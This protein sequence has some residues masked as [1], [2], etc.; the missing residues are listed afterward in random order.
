MK[1]I[2]I[3]NDVR[4]N[5]TISRSGLPE[6]FSDASVLVQ[7]LDARD[8]AVPIQSSIAG[9]II[10]VLYQG[11]DQ[12]T[13]GRYKLVLVENKGEAS[14][15]TIDHADAFELVPESRMAAGCSCMDVDL[16]SNIEAG[17]PGTKGEDAKINGHNAVEIVAGENVEIHQEG[18]VLTIGAT[19]GG[20]KPYQSLARR[21]EYLYEITFAQ[22][23]D[24]IPANAA[25]IGGCTSFVRNGRL[26]RNLDWKYDDTPSFIVRTK[27]FDGMAFNSAVNDSS[28]SDTALGQLP[29]MVV[30]GVNR[31]G[32][33]GSVHVLYN[34]FDWHG[35]GNIPLT[36]VMYEILTRV[37][38]MQSIQSELSP[39]IGDIATTPA[40][41]AAEYL[42]QFVITDGVTSYV[43]TPTSDGYELVDI[44][45][46]PKLAN[47]KWVAD[48]EVERDAVNMQLR[49]TGVERWNLIGEDTELSD[50]RFTKC[51]ESAD[52]LSEFVGIDDT[53]KD[54]TDAELTTVYNLAHTAYSTRTR[55][56]QLWQTMHS[57]VYGAN[58][59]E[60]LWC[61][62]KWDKD[63]VAQS[64]GGG[65]QVNSD[66][67]ATSGKAEILN[68][69]FYSKP[70]NKVFEI[71][72]ET[73][74]LMDFNSN[75]YNWRYG[76]H[77]MVLP[78]SL[79]TDVTVTIDGHT[80]NTQLHSG[81]ISD[82]WMMPLIGNLE[83]A[84]AMLCFFL[85][86]SY[87]SDIPFT[88]DIFDIKALLE[89]G[90]PLF[91]GNF[92]PDGGVPFIVVNTNVINVDSESSITID[93]NGHTQT[94]GIGQ[95]I[96]G[97]DF[98]GLAFCILDSLILYP[99]IPACDV[100]LDGEVNHL[101]CMPSDLNGVFV[102][103][104]PVLTTP[105]YINELGGS[106][107]LPLFIVQGICLLIADRNPT[108]V[109]SV[110]VYSGDVRTAYFESVVSF[111]E[112]SDGVFESLILAEAFDKN[113][114]FASGDSLQ[115]YVPEKKL[116][117]RESIGS[118]EAFGYK[119]STAPQN[120]AFESLEFDSP[121]S[122]CSFTD[123]INRNPIAIYEC[124]EKLLPSHSVVH[125]RQ[126]AI[127]DDYAGVVRIEHPGEAVLFGTHFRL[128]DIPIVSYC[129]NFVDVLGTDEDSF[130]G[131]P[132][133]GI[134]FTPVDRDTVIAKRMFGINDECTHMHLG[135]NLM[136][137]TFTTFVDDGR[138]TP[139][140]IKIVSYKT[141]PPNIQYCRDLD[142]Y[143][144]VLGEYVVRNNWVDLKFHKNADNQWESEELAIFS[145]EVSVDGD[146]TIVKGDISFRGENPN[147][148][149]EIVDGE[150]KTTRFV[151][152]GECVVYGS[153]LTLLSADLSVSSVPYAGFE[154]LF[155]DC[156]G[157][158]GAYFDLMC[159]SAD[160]YAFY[161]MFKNSGLE[162]YSGGDFIVW[163]ESEYCGDFAFAEMFEGSNITYLDSAPISCVNSAYRML[164]NCVNLQYFCLNNIPMK[165]SYKEIAAGCSN[166][167]EVYLYEDFINWCDGVGTKDWLK[168][169]PTTG[170]LYCSDRLGTDETIERGADYCPEG[171]TVVNSNNN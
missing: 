60:N 117:W 70:G 74:F 30:D 158:V 144:E 18:N 41:D 23:P 22:L 47:F 155:E 90:E 78:W 103:E 55:N 14:M 86:N 25:P 149:T 154:S 63:Y 37:T 153:P 170:I 156:S 146:N 71:N 64:G 163:I 76:Y 81:I 124:D 151:I 98:E 125:E 115:R 120:L 7:L 58:G 42:L 110:S 51:Y 69:P 93:I 50:L 53:T 15:A 89:K 13:V 134:V 35:D 17:I 19:G 159:L 56:G 105:L 39:I 140:R 167:Q 99:E 88:T 95:S 72:G 147:G 44:T 57:V 33:M 118:R 20:S 66:W 83:A 68:K 96:T 52:R 97:E 16:F 123:T 38:S 91:M 171:W 5:W 136:P 28:M 32:I 121:V 62:E 132:Y 48:A 29:Y 87:E 161:R 1:R 92:I 77:S 150:H 11:K 129:G 112:C 131:N 104:G 135:T 101:K 10:S 61:Q 168:D 111:E 49:P 141:T 107:F 128:G 165:D 45:A 160:S 106:G 24:Y 79:N 143:D 142:Q 166:L 26:Y 6:D 109:H 157:I 133:N 75:M 164:A 169:T 130:D 54:S 65:E 145:K 139:S 122:L 40:L 94:V 3:G 12:K 36:K 126:R 21:D 152:E 119:I 127:L 102:S 82:E 2:R 73:A 114:Y 137:M 116:L 43:L 27:D 31:H 34:D 148:L 100:Y 4:V 162:F 108:Y 85:S 59:M 113:V 8:R 67:E 138:N 9:N 46:N 80:V 84:R